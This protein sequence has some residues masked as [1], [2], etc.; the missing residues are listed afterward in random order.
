M[1]NK[2]MKATEPSAEALR[3]IQY[4]TA[5][6]APLSKKWMWRKHRIT[7]SGLEKFPHTGPMLLVANH[8]GFLDPFT[9][10]LA[11]N[12]QISWMATPSLLSEKGALPLVMYWWGVIPK[13][14]FVADPG[15]IKKMKQWVKLGGGVGVFPEG[16]RNWDGH[17]T[18][19]MPGTEKLVKLL[20]VPVVTARILNAYRQWPRWAE[21]PRRGRVHVQFDPPRRFD[22]KKSSNEEIRRYLDERIT[23]NPDEYPSWPVV[24]EKLARG[25]TNVVWACPTCQAFESMREDDDY[26]WCSSCGARWRVGEDLVLYPA[27]RGTDGEPRKLHDV[28]LAIGAELESRDMVPDPARFERD[29][30]LLE[31][32]PMELFDITDDEPSP[33]TRGNLV[34]T[35]AGLEV[36]A[37]GGEVRWRATMDELT[38]VVVDMRRRLQFRDRKRSY[39]AV[40]PT[41]SVVKWELIARHWLDR[42]KAE[43]KAAKAR[44]G[45]DAAK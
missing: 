26:T 38:A 40:L 36:R 29:G 43:A 4:S 5:V 3:R 7:A 17:S 20:D 11:C 33:V 32:E 9:V 14:K 44:A 34:L 8:A 24:G 45:Q 22:K 28:R 30:V 10:I 19:M 27:D 21:Y 31:S 37:T 6:V 42:A 1:V 16:Q 12:R 23:I 2:R 25:I 18:P 39:E 15:A 41:E 35:R 13:K